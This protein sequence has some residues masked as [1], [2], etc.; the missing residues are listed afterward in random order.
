[1]KTWKRDL[2]KAAVYAQLGVAEYYQYD[3]RGE[4]L[5]PPLQGSRLEGGEYRALAEPAAGG[6]VSEALGLRL[7][8][9]AG[10]LQFY[11]L[12]SGERLLSP[13]E[14]AA[15]EAAQAA[16]EAA[17]AAAAE[18][19]AEAEAAR[20]EAAET[21]AE[22]AVEARREAEARLAELRALLRDRLPPAE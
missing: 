18:T 6:L 14:R 4:Y 7:V 9:E 19:R 13:E 15:A 1:K 17:R 20:A 8:L 11:D 10:R 5:Q 16:A 21:R 2:Q 22:A 3:P 12:A